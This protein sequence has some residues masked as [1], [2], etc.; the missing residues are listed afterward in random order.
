MPEHNRITT[1]RPPIPTVDALMS[2]AGLVLPPEMTI[3]E[4]LDRLIRHESA[5]ASVVDDEGRFRG[6]LTEKDCLRILVNEAYASEGGAGTVGNYGSRVADVLRPGMSLFE[7]TEV[8]LRG[9]FPALPVLDDDKL[10]GRLRRHD[11]L[12]GIR[13]FL[14]DVEKVRRR[15]ADKQ[16]RSAERP[17]SIEDMQREAGRADPESLSGLFSRNR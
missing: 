8:F 17:S 11:L 10:V 4:A 2:K 9:N 14:R 3:E 5:A 13:Q 6:M 12:K 15:A 1:P 7:A 16:A